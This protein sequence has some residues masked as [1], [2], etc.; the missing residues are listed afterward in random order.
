MTSATFNPDTKKVAVTSTATLISTIALAGTLVTVFISG[1]KQ[2]EQKIDPGTSKQV[3][4][5]AADSVVGDNDNG[6]W[7]AFFRPKSTSQDDGKL[8]DNYRLAG[9]YFEFGATSDKRRA[10]VDDI[11][12][13]QQHIVSVGQTLNDLLVLSIDNDNILIRTLAGLEERLWLSFRTS[14]SPDASPNGPAANEPAV[15]EA[16]ADTFG[17]KRVGE[18]RWVFERDKL[19]DYYKELM[20]EPERLVKVFDSLKP[21]YTPDGKIDGYQVEVFGEEK[22]FDSTGLK[23]GDVV[24]SVNSIQMTNRRRAEYLISEFVNNR[25]NVVVMDIERDGQT[26][27]F[28]YQIR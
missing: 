4:D 2:P 8:S 19:I 5:F 26:S 11:A 3:P 12:G 28:I 25:I 1:Y 13:K 17:G 16:A 24:R 21:L 7:T 10:I 14:Q 15:S 23:P 20:S 22:F 9:T 6:L 18:N 27:K